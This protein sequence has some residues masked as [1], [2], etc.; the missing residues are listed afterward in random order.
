MQFYQKNITYK[1]ISDKGL[2]LQLIDS[3]DGKWTIW[4]KDAKDKEK[5][6]E[7]FLGLKGYSMGDTF[8]ISYA[9]KENS[10]IG[11]EGN[12]ITYT[13]RTIYSVMPQIDESA[14]RTPQAQDK[15]SQ[16]ANIAPQGKQDETFWDKKAY[17]QC[18]WNYWLEDPKDT[19]K[20]RVLEQADMDLVWQV[21]KQIEEDAEKRFNSWNQLGEKLKQEPFSPRIDRG[22]HI[23]T[24]THTREELEDI[25]PDIQETADEMA[26]ESID[27]SNIPF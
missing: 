12:P 26:R 24:S 1:G 21:F 22:D 10:F 7:A 3:E 23:T 4:K 13:Q 6:S 20:T 2:T 5:D 14:I 25:A 16:V 11:K 9:E 17:K 8:G 19:N 27:T 18:L 15:P